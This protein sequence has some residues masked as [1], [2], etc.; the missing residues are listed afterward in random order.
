MA[1][2]PAERADDRIRH[3]QAVAADLR[4][5]DG[6]LLRQR[7]EARRAWRNFRSVAQQRRRGCCSRREPPVSPTPPLRV[8]G[9]PDQQ[10][11]RRIPKRPTL[12][13]VRESDSGARLPSHVR[14][15]GM[16]P[17]WGGLCGVIAK[18]RRAPPRRSA[19]GVLWTRPMRTTWASTT[20]LGHR[21]PHLVLRR[22]CRPANLGELR[23]HRHW[24]TRGQRPSRNSLGDPMPTSERT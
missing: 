22:T 17:T 14:G 16:R 5:G 12:M 2:G 8:L 20:A 7:Q 1:H 18:P 15:A 9:D 4:F 3:E 21:P 10:P 13:L 6:P 19:T 11:G 24:G 23:G